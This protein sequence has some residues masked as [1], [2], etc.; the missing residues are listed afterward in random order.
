MTVDRCI[1]LSRPVHKDAQRRGILNQKQ[2][3]KK[4][5]CHHAREEEAAAGQEDVDAKE[6]D[7]DAQEKDAC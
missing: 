5:T 2:T 7:V 6:K 1:H 3:S 4:R